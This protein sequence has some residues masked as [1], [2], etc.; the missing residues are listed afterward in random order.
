MRCL[1]KSGEVEEG[2]SV[3]RINSWRD[4]KKRK[5]PQ[6]PR[7]YDPPSR[8]QSREHLGIKHVARKRQNLPQAELPHPANS[9]T[10]QKTNE[11]Q[12]VEKQM[13]EKARKTFLK[14]RF[15]P[16]S[17]TKHFLAATPKDA[18]D[19]C[20]HTPPSQTLSLSEG[21]LS[22]SWATTQPAGGMGLTIR[23]YVNIKM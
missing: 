10:F 4:C 1:L 21:S 7:S 16:P 22:K 17:S 15:G 3:R 23:K 18:Q 8:P 19:V 6:N 9:P 20:T 5:R 12:L 2:T 14:I 13:C 11:S